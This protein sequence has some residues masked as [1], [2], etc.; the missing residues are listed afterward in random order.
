M[1]SLLGEVLFSEYSNWNEM[2]GL[3][4]RK[5]EQ[6]GFHDYFLISQPNPMMWPSLKSAQRDDFNEW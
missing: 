5:S 6:N 2:P 4:L 1:C 3:Q